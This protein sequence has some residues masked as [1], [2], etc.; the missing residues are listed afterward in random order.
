[1]TLTPASPAAPPIRIVL[2]ETSHPGNI[3]ACARAMKTMGLTDL[4]LVAPATFPHAEATALASG[5][6]DV[7]ARASVVDTL[8]EAIAG[9]GLVV[10]ATARP[11]SQYYWPVLEVR[12]AA[13]KV[14]AESA[15]GP[16]AVVFGTERTGLTN[17]DLERCNALL[18]IPANPEYES[19]NLAQAV[20]VVAYEL[21]RARGVAAIATPRE[22][23]LATADELERFYGHLDEVMTAVG[24]TDR[25]GSEHLMRRYRRLYGRAEIDQ[26]EMNILRGLLAAVQATVAAR[27][28]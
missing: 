16:V 26:V 20:Q 2:V 19:L 13:D 15:G 28:P 3:G 22:A 1:M 11:R 10:G 21:Y 6:D 17:T 5:A 27:R 24:F 7:L 12:E 4:R 23:P 8:P 18:Y 14:V 25:R 9:C